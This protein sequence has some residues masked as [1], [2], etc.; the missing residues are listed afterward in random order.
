MG[1]RRM[2]SFGRTAAPAGTRPTGQAGAATTQPRPVGRPV[3][4]RPVGPRPA[5]PRPSAA[6]YEAPTEQQLAATQPKRRAA[7][8]AASPKRGGW[9]VVLQFVLGLV[10]I[11]V[12]AGTIVWL[13]GHF[14]G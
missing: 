3:G 1:P 2:D 14:Y 6:N 8:S 11:V 5:G 9:K 4:A 13:Y 10:I 12:V 7:K